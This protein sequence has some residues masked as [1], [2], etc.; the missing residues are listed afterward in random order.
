MISPANRF[1]FVHVNKTAGRSIIQALGKPPLVN[2]LQIVF[3]NHLSL[4]EIFDIDGIDTERIKFTN[5]KYLEKEKRLRRGLDNQ[6]SISK[7]KGLK[8][9]DFFK[10]AV[11]RNPWSRAV[12]M[13]LHS[14][15]RGH[16]CLK[17]K[18]NP[19]NVDFDTYCE[20]MI[21]ERAVSNFM[22]RWTSSSLEWMKD[23]NGKINMNFIIK[24]ENLKKDWLSVCNSINIDHRPLPWVGKS[25]SGKFDTYQKYYNSN[26]KKL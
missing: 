19:N 20:L 4:N 18:I 12:S 5:N 3:S 1:V 9:D 13:F 16:P 8:I 11:T 14:E 10:F 26:T 21:K 15:R 22:Q 17:K 23:K 25:S 7:L 24:F 6:N 2:E